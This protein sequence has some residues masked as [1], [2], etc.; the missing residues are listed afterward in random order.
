M[1]KQKVVIRVTMNNAK[2]RTKALTIAVKL[3]ELEDDK[4][5]VVGNGVDSVELT[6]M[7]R[8]QMG[9]AELVRVVAYDEK[10]E[11]KEEKDG[12]GKSVQVLASQGSY[13]QYIYS[14]CPY[15]SYDPYY[16][17]SCYIM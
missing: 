14:P 4:I 7:L 2:K 8:K 11:K 15:Q 6:V 5:I 17:Q 13:P 3:P 9:F 16:S 10:K 1:G 12:K